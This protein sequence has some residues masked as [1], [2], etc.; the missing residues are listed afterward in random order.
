MLYRATFAAC[1]GLLL[2]LGT[3]HAALTPEQYTCQKTVAKQGRVYL[4]KR[5][6][7]LSSCE[8]K[9]NSGK[10]PTT[11][12]CALETKTLDKLNKA[13]Q[14]LRDK[15]GPACPDAVVATLAFGG[16]CFGVTTSTALADCQIAGHDA[17]ADA[18]LNT[19]YGDPTPVNICSGGPND[20]RLCSVPADCPMGGVCGP[21]V[22][23]RTC[24]GGA[25]D[26][27]ACEETADCPDGDCV[28]GDAQQDCA[29]SLVRYSSARAVAS[30]ASAEAIA[31]VTRVAR[32]A[33]A[34]KNIA[35]PATSGTTIGRTTRCSRMAFRRLA[36]GR[37]RGRCPSIHAG[38]GERPETTRSSR[39]R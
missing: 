29:A 32:L 4:K 2:L 6:K 9:I 25:N 24:D 12:D 31:I 38:Q 26:G 36:R 21:Y 39:S 8:N 13:E 23:D 30:C 7:A 27:L 11:T 20:G 10:L 37:R 18:I 22:S 28:L 14:K 3:A 35:A 17:A 19:A 34:T 16:Q 5:I 33:S 15:V 1:A